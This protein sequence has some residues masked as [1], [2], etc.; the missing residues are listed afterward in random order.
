LCTADGS[1]W[2]SFLIKP[3]SFQGCFDAVRKLLSRGKRSKM[4]LNEKSEMFFYDYSLMP[5]SVQENYLSVDPGHA[6]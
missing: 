2:K 3:V 5:P 4:D 6:R 1:D